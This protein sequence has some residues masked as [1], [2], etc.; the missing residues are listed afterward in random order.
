MATTINQPIYLVLGKRVKETD[1]AILITVWS[2]E[3]IDLDEPK[4]EWFPKGQIVDSKF[5]DEK[6]EA[7]R[8]NVKKW[9]MDQKGLI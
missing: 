3:G 9:I 2:V 8:F 4:N 6:T 7:D 5:E 1:K